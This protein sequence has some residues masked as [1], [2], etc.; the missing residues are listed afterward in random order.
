MWLVLDFAT[1][2]GVPAA[3][4]VPPLSPPLG[5]EV[6]QPVGALDHV[7]VVLDDDERVARVGQAVEDVDELAHVLE[8]EPVVGSS[9]T[10]RACCPVARLAELR[11][12]LDPLRLAALRALLTAGPA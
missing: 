9:R 10:Y 3:T 4:I 5:A 1:C 7:E 2:S 6:D 11:R 12:Q 8:V